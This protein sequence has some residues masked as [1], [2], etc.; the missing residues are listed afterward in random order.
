MRQD[1]LL[2][3]DANLLAANL[4]VSPGSSQHPIGTANV[5]SYFDIRPDGSQSPTSL[6]S[7][8]S[9]AALANASSNTIVALTAL[10]YLP[11]PVLV[12]D[13]LKAVVAANEAMGRLLGIDPSELANDDGPVATVTDVLQGSHMSQLGIEIL[14]HGSPILISWDDFLDGIVQSG[15]QAATD[16]QAALDGDKSGAASGSTIRSGDSTPTANHAARPADSLGREQESL[17][18]NPSASSP[19]T[20]IDSSVEVIITSFRERSPTANKNGQPVRS[21]DDS[22][23]QANMIVS[24]WSIDDVSYHTLTFTNSQTAQTSAQTAKTTRRTVNRSTTLS[25]R[26]LGSSSSSSSGKRSVAGTISSTGSSTTPS[27]LISTPTFPPLGP[28]SANIGSSRSLFQKASRLKDAILNSVNMPSYAMWKDETFGIPNK[29]LLALHPDGAPFAGSNQRDWLSEFTLYTEDFESELSV[30]EFPIIQLCRSQ[31]RFDGRRIGMR[32]P[33]TKAK[34]VFEVLGE[35]IFDDGSD[36]FLGGIVIFKDVTQYTKRIAEQIEENEK[37]FE[38]IANLIPI[39]VWRTTPEGIHDWYSQRWYDYTGLT[40]EESFGEG[41]RGAFHPEDMPVTSARWAHSLAT[42]EEYITEYRCKRADGQ[43]RWMLGRATPF[44]DDKGKI[45]KWFGTCTDIHELVEARREAR[46]VRE[47]LQRVM[48]HAQVTLWAID[49]KGV[50]TLL[51]GNMVKSPIAHGKA[52]FIGQHIDDIVELE[53]WR[54]AVDRLLSGSSKDEFIES[55]VGGDRWFR[56]RGLPLYAE[57]TDKGN[58]DA[59]VIDGIIW[60]SVDSTELRRREAELKA[61]EKANAKLLANEAAAKEA[62]KMKSQFLA[63]MSH[64]IRTPIAGV[65]GMSELL[66]DTNLNDEQ[67]EFA[68]NINRSAN[69]LLTVIND[70][71]DFSKVESGRLDIEDVQFNLS[72]VIR[73]IGKMTSFAAQRKNLTYESYIEPRIA[74]DFKVTGDPGRLRQIIQNLLTNS[75]KFTTQGSISLSVHT[76]SETQDTTTLSFEVRDTGIGIE[77]E[78][79]KKLFKPFSQADSSTARRFGGTGLGL[80][81]S[82]NLVELMHGQIEL[83]SKLGQGTTARFWL[84]FK[85]VQNQAGEDAIVDISS[86]PDRL[87]SEVSMSLASDPD[88]TPPSTP[89]VGTKIDTPSRSESIQTSV[90]K[91]PDEFMNLAP[92]AR[93]KIHVLVVE[94]NPINQ[95]IATKTIKKLGFSVSAVWNGQE[96]LDY[97]LQEPTPSH[98]RPDIILMD[99]QMPIMDGYRATHTIRT[100]EPFKGRVRD[101]PIVAMTASAIQ[102]DK[103]KCQKAGMDDYLSKPVRAPVLEKMLLKWSSQGQH[104]DSTRRHE[105]LSLESEYS[106][107]SSAP[108]RPH[109][110][111]LSGGRKAGFAAPSTSDHSNMRPAQRKRTPSGESPSNVHDQGKAS[112]PNVASS[113]RES[114]AEL[115]DDSVNTQSVIQQHRFQNEEEASILRDDKMLAVTD[116]PTAPRRSLSGNER[117][118]EKLQSGHKLTRENLD[119]HTSDQHLPDEARMGDGKGEQP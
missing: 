88:R 18:Q 29:A 14:V 67:R 82:K 9:S 113:S 22:T 60:V 30:D 85:K 41:W 66:L 45:V 72:V 38:Y 53:T 94:D 35:P 93:A 109:S 25:P 15:Q 24:T 13:S 101:I 117:K 83:E 55:H 33:K 84:P 42:G 20:V 57:H 21:A 75:L 3:G 96:V 107:E 100:S 12:L 37:Q 8:A 86:I 73:D 65:I 17:R 59:K 62:S 110:P 26:P 47:Q 31:K 49:T 71:L 80:T 99:V 98:P 103:E 6:R 61:Q 106:L 19:A 69:S 77:E 58:A 105:S 10:Q 114:S 63:N 115:G 2:T 89:P 23:L 52:P 78:V 51:E 11:M 36:E 108:S 76:V 5:D 40:V 81:I 44:L 91:I 50:I 90:N 54:P 116:I 43:W 95:Q 46:N 87:Q 39:M 112:P 48:E 16:R 74:Q 4:A 102:G 28:P 56:T 32:H 27:P 97:L 111:L 1:R 7:V 92:E 119:K 79:R 118:S 70:I 64:E 68:E 34:I 104:R